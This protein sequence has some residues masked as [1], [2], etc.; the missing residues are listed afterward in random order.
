MMPI[1]AEIV[2]AQHNGVCVCVVGAGDK[3]WVK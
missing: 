2:Q 1:K 3:E